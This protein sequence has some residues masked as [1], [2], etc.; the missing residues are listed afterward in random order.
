MFQV[1]LATMAILLEGFKAA[2]FFT[3]Q[4]RFQTYCFLSILWSFC[5]SHL[6]IMGCLNKTPYL[7]THVYTKYCCLSY[8]R[9]QAQFF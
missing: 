9:L 2:I 1:L 5:V 3:Y 4:I 6:G 7:C 8:P